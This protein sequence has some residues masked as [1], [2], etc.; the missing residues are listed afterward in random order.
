VGRDF[1][2]HLRAY[3]RHLDFVSCP[4]DPDVWMQPATK[5]DGLEYYE[6]VLLYMDDI[7]TVSD[8]AEK[9]LREQIGRYFELKEES[10]G[11]P[12]LYMGG[13][14]CKVELTN[15]V[16]VWTFSSSQYIQLAVKNVEDYLQG[17]DIKLPSKAEMPI[18]T[19]CCLAID[20]SLELGPCDAACYQ[21]L[22]GILRWMVELGSVDICIETSMMS[23]GPPGSSVSYV[24]LPEEVSQFRDGFHPERPSD[25]QIRL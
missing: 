6:F 22:L 4:A 7:L 8:N 15:G 5:G 14:V 17:K 11:P 1:R 21:S 2:N 12:K 20:V 3:M 19:S 25:R 18:M 16:K 9:V 23:S 10:I 13:H 24:C